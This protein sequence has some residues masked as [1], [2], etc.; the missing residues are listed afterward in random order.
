MARAFI[1][2]MV[3]NMPT[4]RI[5]LDRLASDITLRRICGRERICD[6]PHESIFSRAF[7]ESSR[8]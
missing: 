5:L 7:D 2:K 1:A 4:T 6:V 8:T 3:C